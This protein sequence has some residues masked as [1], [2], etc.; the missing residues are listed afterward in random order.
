MD[1]FRVAVRIRPLSEG[2]RAKGQ[3]ECCK[4]LGG[5][6]EK[7]GVVVISKAAGAGH[8]RSQRSSNC[9]YAFDHAFGPDSTQLE[10]YESVAKPLIP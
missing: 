1:N 6:K 5:G 3:Q 10:V 9:D 7:Q 2:E 8:L 4:V